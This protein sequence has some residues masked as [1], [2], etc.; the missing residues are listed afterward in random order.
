LGSFGFYANDDGLIYDVTGP[1]EDRTASPAW[2]AGIR[3]GDRLDLS[4]MRCLPYDAVTC[5]SVLTALGGVQ[6]AV[7]GRS[8]TLD[9]APRLITRGMYSLL[10]KSDQA[11][12]S[13]RPLFF[14]IKSPESSSSW[15]PHGWCGRVRGQ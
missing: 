5:R 3:E 2:N 8:I 11:T 4:K 7:P 12:F 10:R 15:L 6:F 9:V 1:F 14:W 13:S